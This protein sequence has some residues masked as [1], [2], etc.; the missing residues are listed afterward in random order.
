ML[1]KDKD[2]NPQPQWEKK[3]LEHD[4]VKPDIRMDTGWQEESQD[5]SSFVEREMR[6]QKRILR[7]YLLL[8]LVPVILGIAIL[9]FGRSDR[10]VVTDEIKKQAPTIVRS[11]IQDQVRPAIQTEVKTQVSSSLGEIGELKT[12]QESLT[13]EVNQIKS[14]DA[15]LTPEE[16]NVIK[17][18][19]AILLQREA[20]IKR[21]YE[22]VETLEGQMKN[23]KLEDRPGRLREMRKEATIPQ[24]NNPQ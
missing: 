19:S 13:N 8:L 23:Q 9:I 4:L 10:R 14:S 3:T 21:L 7:F 15:R 12:R 5:T 24:R 16:I 20:E 18:S 6:R 2:Q 11:E 1:R 22:R 17:R